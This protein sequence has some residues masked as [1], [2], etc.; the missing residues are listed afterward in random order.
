[1]SLNTTVLAAS[2]QCIVTVT[3]IVG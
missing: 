2:V 3:S 1:M